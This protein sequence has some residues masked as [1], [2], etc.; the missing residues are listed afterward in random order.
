M[1]FDNS[2]LDNPVNADPAKDNPA[3]GPSTSVTDPGQATGQ[4]VQPNMPPAG[5]MDINAA[6]AD[7][8]K[9][10]GLTNFKDIGG[11]AKSYKEQQAYTTR[12]SQDIASMREMIQSMQ[13]NNQQSSGKPE[14][15]P[16]Q[17][18]EL[19]EQFNNKFLDN[20]TET[21]K[22]FVSNIIKEM[23]KEIVKP[24]EEQTKS[25]AE[26]KNM[27]EK[28]EMRNTQAVAFF[29]SNPDATAH[30]ED[31]KNYVAQ[32]KAVLDKLSEV[33]GVNPFEFAY[34]AVKGMNAPNNPADLLKNDN[35]V[36]MAMQDQNFVNKVLQ[37]H[38]QSIKGDQPPTQIAGQGAGA[39]LTPPGANNRPTSITEATKK[40][41]AAKGW[42]TP[43]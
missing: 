30:I 43:G 17:I 27:K 4:S 12:L 26:W 3:S 37:M 28:Q 14:L 8:L 7:L 15:S 32:N 22:E 40:F 5:G 34:H 18:E 35:F 38:M 9:E 31:I 36:N 23:G 20:P 39:P 19:N 10:N 6:V 11:L 25:L 2:M 42:N 33:E 16:E 21:L 29:K 41:F 24:I 13:S 1:T